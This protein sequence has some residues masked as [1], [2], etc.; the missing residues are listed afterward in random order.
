MANCEGCVVE[1]KGASKMVTDELAW[2]LCF[3]KS[4]DSNI[5]LEPETPGLSV[6]LPEAQRLVCGKEGVS[7]P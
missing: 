5:S 2:C 6:L 1:W 4:M 7:N 3:S